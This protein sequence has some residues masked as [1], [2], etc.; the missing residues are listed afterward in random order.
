MSVPPICKYTTHTKAYYLH[1]SIPPY[2]TM[3]PPLNNVF[4]NTPPTT[5]HTPPW[6]HKP[7]PICKYTTHTKAYYLHASIPPYPT[8]LP[9]LNNVFTNTPPTTTQ[10]SQATTHNTILPTCLAATPDTC[11]N[12]SI[13]ASPITRVWNSHILAYVPT[14]PL[15]TTHSWTPYTILYF[16]HIFMDIGWP[17]GFMGMSGAQRGLWYIWWV[18]RGRI[19]NSR[20]YHAM[21]HRQ[22]YRT[23][24]YLLC[25]SRSPVQSGN[26]NS[27]CT[28]GYFIYYDSSFE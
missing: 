26:Y 20:M 16:T 9:P 28:L 1:A 15:S 6:H 27:L 12:S 7:P 3:L 21:N 17:M 18:K 5:T 22:L 8:M 13:Y 2:P 19:F 11:Q 25:T 4:T 23:G 24:S 10:T 14:T